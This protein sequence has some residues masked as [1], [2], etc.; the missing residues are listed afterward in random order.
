MTGDI[1]TKPITHITFSDISELVERETEE[2]V[3]LEFKRSLSTN[4]GRPD[5]WMVDQK[6]VGN[7]ARDDIAKEIVAFANAY[8]GVLILGVEES[9]DT[10]R[11]AKAI[12][13]PYIPRVS[14]CAERLEQALRSIVDPPLLSLEVRGVEAEDGNGVIVLRVGS[15]PSAPHGVGRP[16]SAFV[17]RS[18]SSEPLTMRDMQSMFYE[19][20]ARLERVTAIIE[21]QSERAKNLAGDWQRGVLRQPD[22]NT[23]ML[24]TNG[25]LFQLSFVSS[26]DMAIDNLPDLVT[27]KPK[28]LPVLSLN[29][30]VDVPAWT[31]Q[32]KR[33]YRTLSFSSGYTGKRSE[34][35]VRA[36]GVITMSIVC[37][38]ARLHPSWFNAIIAHGFVLSEWLRR[39]HGRPDIDFVLTGSF[40]K[41]GNPAVPSHNGAFETFVEIPWNQVK[42]GPYSVGSRSQFP[43]AF[44]VI[45]REVFDLFGSFRS[46][47]LNVEWDLAFGDAGL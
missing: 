17:R 28:R 43:A 44:D 24:G 30:L 27:E 26:D 18:A 16:P 7:A 9:D 34:V 20:R 38:D 29:S 5:R 41:A 33:K 22:S 21:N 23:N 47:K 31:N 12:F 19:R 10:P 3:R 32:W 4:D 2:G 8:G 35:E 46:S 15:S 6:S 1:F 25:L 14:D 37:E 40:H 45:E 36:D 39:F 42:L 11:R 13:E